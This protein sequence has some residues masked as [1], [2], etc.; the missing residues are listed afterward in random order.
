MTNERHKKFEPRGGNLGA[1]RVSRT[2]RF[3]RRPRKSNLAPGVDV[4][5]RQKFRLD[6]HHVGG[7]EEQE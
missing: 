7:K 6:V 4:V 5:N 3:G 2:T 1:Q